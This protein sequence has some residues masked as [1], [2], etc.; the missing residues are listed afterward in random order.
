MGRT[1][2]P[3]LVGIIGDYTSL[4]FSLRLTL[5]FI[6]IMVISTIALIAARNKQRRKVNNI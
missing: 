6:G 1:V 2:L 3:G 4:A 5:I